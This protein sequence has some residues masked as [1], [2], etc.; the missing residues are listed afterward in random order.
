MHK[1]YGSFPEHNPS[2]AA[3]LCLCCSA[4]CTLFL[5]MFWVFANIGVHIAAIAIAFKYQDA[6][7][8]ENKHIVSLSE[9][10]FMNSFPSL[11]CLVVMLIVIGFLFRGFA[12]GDQNQ[13]IGLSCFLALLILLTVIY[14]LLVIIFGII[15]LS[16]QFEAC[17]SEARIVNIFVILGVVLNL[18]S[19]GITCKCSVTTNSK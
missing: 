7:C 10:I 15:E 14:Y 13:T 8:Y 19:F 12:K 4:T 6:T 2:P 3:A 16:H 17:Q 5:S 1:T 11:I 18:V 9:W